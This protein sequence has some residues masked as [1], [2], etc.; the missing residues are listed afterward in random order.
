MKDE[1]SNIKSNEEKKWKK[2]FILN[3]KMKK[4]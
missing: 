1:K 3:L 4:N 2:Y